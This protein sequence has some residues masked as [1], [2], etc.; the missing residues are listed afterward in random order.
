MGPKVLK[1]HQK[2]VRKVGEERAPKRTFLIFS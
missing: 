2:K 1:T